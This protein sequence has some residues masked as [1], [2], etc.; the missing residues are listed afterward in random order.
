MKTYE[1]SL[2]DQEEE[3]L[4]AEEEISTKQ[5]ATA[6]RRLARAEKLSDAKVLAT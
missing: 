6:V 4:T 3:I 1:L 2:A 5:H